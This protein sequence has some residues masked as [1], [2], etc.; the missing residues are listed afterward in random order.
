MGAFEGRHGEGLTWH[1]SGKVQKL[2]NFKIFSPYL[3]QYLKKMN[4]YLAERWSKKSRLIL[5]SAV[6]VSLG[7]TI[8]VLIW[9]LYWFA[10]FSG[11]VCGALICWLGRVRER[12]FKIEFEPNQPHEIRVFV[13]QVLLRYRWPLSEFYHQSREPD[14][15][16]KVTWSIDQLIERYKFPKEPELRAVLIRACL[17]NMD[18]LTMRNPFRG[19]L[20][21]TA[22]YTL[23]ALLFMIFQARNSGSSW[24]AAF[25]TT[26]ILAAFMV[27]V[28]RKIFWPLQRR[29]MDK[30][31]KRQ[32]D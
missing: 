29:G 24:I 26:A 2:N 10:L 17:K 11:V 13:A 21:M 22:Y 30:E 14:I 9:K 15:E 19:T 27:I 1:I 16:T 8:L 6:L 28:V 12:Q 23:L 3:R 25:I 5:C 18:Y 20:R 31:A 32:A 4:L 7:V